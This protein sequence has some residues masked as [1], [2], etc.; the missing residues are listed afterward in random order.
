MEKILVLDFGGQTCQ[1]IARRIRDIGVYSEILPGDTK[2]TDKIMEDVKGI[3]LS[4]SPYSVYDKDSPHVDNRVFDIGVPVLGICYGAQQIT[5]LN[6]G[7]VMP[8]DHR[9]YGRARLHFDNSFDLFQNVPQEFISWMS[10]GDTIVELPEL[11]K[12]CARSEN[13]I[14][15]AFKHKNLPIYGIQFHPEVTHCEYGTR[16]LENFAINICGCRKEWTMQNY[17]DDVSQDIKKQVGDEDVLLLISG[18]V[19]STV[20]AGI[21]LKALPPAQVHLMYVDTGLMRK[22]ETIEVEE[23]LKRLGAKNLYIVNAEEKFLSA[24][25]GKEDPE[26]KRRIIGDLFIKIQQEEI[27]KRNVNASFL[28]QGTLYTDMIESGK[29]VGSKAKVI[30][31]HH[32]VRSPL[33]EQKRRENKIIEPLSMLYKD[34]VRRL[35][36]F[37]GISESVL[38]RH[39]FPGPGLAVRILGEVTKEKCEILREADYIYI[40]ELKNRG[41]YNDIWQAFAVLLPV[42]SV[43]VTGDD[44][45]YGYVLALRAV[46]SSDGMTADAYP[47]PMKDLLEISAMITNRVKSIGRVVYDV[48]SKPPATIEWE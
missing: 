3:I 45:H 20:V 43:G 38:E 33:V 40:N 25:K 32:N 34:E 2:I 35:G 24:L 30:K 4:G 26:E 13:N 46:V 6:G 5:H 23:N 10:H 12:V 44:R 47:F 17:L 8:L 48:S 28:A 9:E 29:G 16:I 31:S 41:L 21:L 7:K 18:G 14:I 36:R 1:L 37:I 27:E 11:Y 42:K 22:N 15:A 19:D 39:P